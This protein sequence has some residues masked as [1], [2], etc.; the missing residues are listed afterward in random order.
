MLAEDNEIKIHL[1]LNKT[2]QQLTESSKLQCKGEGKR[3]LYIYLF[4][5]LFNSFYKVDNLNLVYNIPIR[6]DWIK[7]YQYNSNKN[8]SNNNNS[9]KNNSNDKNDDN[10]SDNN[11]R[12]T[13]E[14]QQVLFKTKHSKDS[15]YHSV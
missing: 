6:I 7:M 5:Y 4:I 11:N 3:I 9:D 15:P 14:Y 1:L 8:N 12:N 2:N 13:T 10:N